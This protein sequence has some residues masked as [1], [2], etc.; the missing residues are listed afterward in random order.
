[1]LD[2]YALLAQVSY[3]EV[4][5]EWLVRRAK[6]KARETAIFVGIITAILLFPELIVLTLVVPYLFG[7]SASNPFPLLLHSP[8]L[9]LPALSL[10]VALVYAAWRSEKHKSDAVLILL[11]EGIVECEHWSDERKRRI[12]SFEYRGYAERRL[13][14]S[15]PTGEPIAFRR[16]RSSSPPWR[17]CF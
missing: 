17:S 15:T 3:N 9:V 2:P 6:D 16:L 4:H 7:Y 11:P 14:L 5:E 8:W 13:L 1:M 10:S 12:K